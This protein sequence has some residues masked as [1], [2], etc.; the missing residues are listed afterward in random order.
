MFIKLIGVGGFS[1][2]FLARKL[3]NGEFY[4]IKLIFKEEI[5]KSKK[6]I[7]VETER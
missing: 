2:V 1:N 4:A 7:I 6:F 3:S 5:F